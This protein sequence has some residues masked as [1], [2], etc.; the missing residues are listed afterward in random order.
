LGNGIVAKHNWRA[1]PAPNRE[2]VVLEAQRRKQR[3][4]SRSNRPRNGHYFS[5][6]P[7]NLE[8][9]AA[10]LLQRVQFTTD[11]GCLFLTSADTP[12]DLTPVMSKPKFEVEPP[13]HAAPLCGDESLP[14]QRLQLLR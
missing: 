8:L 7:L 1:T 6:Q 14:F 11:I 4:H 13:V 12:D 2:T 3:F 9:S 5:R 10:F